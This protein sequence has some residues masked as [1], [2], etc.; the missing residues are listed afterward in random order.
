MRLLN[1]KSEAY[2]FCSSFFF[3]FFLFRYWWRNQLAAKT[4]QLVEYVQVLAITGYLAVDHPPSYLEFILPFQW[5]IFH[6][7]Y[8]F[9]DASVIRPPAPKYDDGFFIQARV[10]QSAAHEIFLGSLFFYAIMIAAI[11]VL[12]VIP[13]TIF[14][15]CARMYFL[16]FLFVLLLSENI[17]RRHR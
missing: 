14:A 13:A 7:P 10:V 1:V 2:S 5:S 3:L 17:C 4:W 8:P 11:F 9:S 16:F 6:L 12:F 15:T